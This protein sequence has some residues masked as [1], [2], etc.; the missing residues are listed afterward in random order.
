MHKKKRRYGNDF[1]QLRTRIWI[2]TIFLFFVAFVVIFLVYDLFLFQ[3]FADPAVNFLNLFVQDYERAFLIYQR[4][5]RT[6]IEL[7]L[8]AAVIFV[9]IILL[10]FYL[11]IFVRYFNEINDGINSILDRNSTLVLSPELSAIEKKIIRIKLELEQKE[12]ASHE[13]EQRKDD[14]VMYLAHDIRTPLTSVIGYLSFLEEAPDMPAEQ[15]TNYTRIA[16][17]KA[18]R[19][20]KMVDEFFEITRFNAQQTELQKKDID[21]T[22]MLMQLAD[23]LTPILDVNRNTIRIDAA[24]NLMVHGDPEKLARVFNNVLKNA[25]SYSTANTEIIISAQEAE[26]GVKIVFQNEGETIPPE[27]LERLFDRFYRVDE[28]RRSQ[29]GGT[30]LGLAIAKEIVLLHGGTISAESQNN[31]VTFTIFIPGSEK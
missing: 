18:N 5:V 11:N 21:I 8:L 20:E 9:F 13:A 16:L 17:E 26:N 6:Y 2:K 19:L 28:S 30:G 29:T 14:L 22:Y 24:D 4:Y 1:G 7:Y 12:R 10:R 23:E 15:R 27:K 3:N 31:T 25:A